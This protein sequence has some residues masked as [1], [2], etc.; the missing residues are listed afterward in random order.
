MNIK[1]NKMTKKDFVNYI[2]T[3]WQ[4]QDN[5]KYINSYIAN[6]KDLGNSIAIYDNKILIGFI[7]YQEL[8]RYPS[9]YVGKKTDQ[10]E[11][12]Q[13]YENILLE[14]HP[15]YRNK[16]LGSLLIEKLTNEIK[17]CLLFTMSEYTNKHIQF[18]TK[19]GFIQI[20]DNPKIKYH[21]FYK[22][23]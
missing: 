9:W 21:L 23:C 22:Y 1:Y 13:L 14:I 19:N 5:A 7:F 12:K 4:D 16:G 15:D 2:T 6:Y 8:I 11:D 3:Y 20:K 10:V 17:D 18:Y